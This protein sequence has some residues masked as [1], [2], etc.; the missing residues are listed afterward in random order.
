MISILSNS[1][2]KTKRKQRHTNSVM[3]VDDKR[4]A[5][6]NHSLYDAKCRSTGAE[7]DANASDFGEFVIGQSSISNK[8]NSSRKPFHNIKNVSKS[9]KKVLFSKNMKKLPEF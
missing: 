3:F 8:S 1:R 2:H 7:F 5:L 9:P 6:L 4:S